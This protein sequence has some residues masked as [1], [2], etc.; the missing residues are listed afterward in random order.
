MDFFSIGDV[1]FNLYEPKQCC[2]WT[3]KPEKNI[4]I[5]KR[6]L[7]VKQ[8]C[9]AVHMS[10]VFSIINSNFRHLSV[11]KINYVIF[12]V[13]PVITIQYLPREKH[14][15]VCVFDKLLLVISHVTSTA[16]DS[17]STK[18]NRQNTFSKDLF[19]HKYVCNLTFA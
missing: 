19:L 8:K 5:S 13:K 9:A 11:N 10:W 4:R 17:S 3:E 1:Q 16:S 12:W 14:I 2:K 7:Y 15:K 6:Y 18:E